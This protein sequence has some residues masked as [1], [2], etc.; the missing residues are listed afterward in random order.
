M[1]K[2]NAVRIVRFFVV[3]A[4][5]TVAGRFAV[6]DVAAQQQAPG[7]EYAPDAVLVQ[8]A[9]SAD[10]ESAAAAEATAEAVS[11]GEIIREFS[12]VPG[13]T[14]LRLP[15][16]ADVMQTIEKL[17]AI[18]GIV[19]AEPDYMVYPTDTI[20]NDTRWAEQWAFATV[21]APL[22]WDVT[23]G[24]ADVVIA[25]IDTGV[26]TTHPDL[27][28]N[29]WTNPGE[30]ADNGIDDDNNGYIDDING[31]D[32]YDNDNNPMDGNS[33][34]THVAGTICAEGN[35]E[36]G[37]V[38]VVWHCKIM[39]LRFMGPN[40][41]F[42]SAVVD[43]LGYLV[44]KQVK[45]SNNSWGGDGYSVSLYNAI[46]NAKAV[47]H[48]FVAAAGNSNNDND[49]VAFYPSSYDLDNIVA[50]AASNE[51]NVMASFS[52]WGAT[53]VDLAA[54]GVNILSTWPNGGYAA[55][56]GTSMSTPLVTG[57]LAT[58]YGLHPGWTYQQARDNLFHTVQ[59][60]DSMTGLTLTGGIPD[61]AAAVA[62]A[63][64][65]PQDP[66]VLVASAPVT[67]QI[68]LAWSDNA[69]NETGYTI[70]RTTDH[71]AWERILT[72]PGGS[73]TASDTGCWSYECFY[74]VQAINDAGYSGYSNVVSVT[75]ILPSGLHVGDLDGSTAIPQPK[76]W[77]AI[78]TIFV[79]DEYHAPVVN[80][81]VTG[82]WSS[83]MGQGSCRTDN[84]G[85][86]LVS[87]RKLKTNIASLSFR[88][89]SITE[90]THPYQP[91]FNHD[92]DGDSTG[93]VIVVMRP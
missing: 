35:N 32:F 65:V 88:I 85:R 22:A 46:N 66:S 27:I 14:Y 39:S 77:D 28:N 79:H 34:G 55:L 30:I 76:Q 20:P 67:N 62:V 47:N 78:V 63:A 21:R 6:A 10:T 87:K 8:F 19:Y 45:L 50:V 48:L 24:A 4:L 73:I 75:P 18:D 25:V 58:L 61:L 93:T 15:L 23:T 59:R 43:A 92:P 90:A 57:A 56:S 17:K 72:L 1:L 3:L 81:T 40:G 84:A 54:P 68:D 53:R 2:I 7:A 86:C 42:S 41:G 5:V 37:V 69:S 38:G 91:N 9:P 16:G 80:A 12:L 44:A 71:V 26:D 33:H 13:L 31:W 29:L 70:E 11:G 60:F 83:K 49:A 89:T 51:T 82:V 64:A 36:L 74:R 52:N